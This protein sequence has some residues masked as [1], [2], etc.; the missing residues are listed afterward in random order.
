MKLQ[1]NMK[2]NKSK[3]IF[4]I[5]LDRT[6]LTLD[7]AQITGIGHLMFTFHLNPVQ[8]IIKGNQFLHMLLACS[9]I[10]LLNNTIPIK[11]MLI[12]NPQ[13]LQFSKRIAIM[14]LMKF[15]KVLKA[16]KIEK[17]HHLISLENSHHLNRN[18]K[19]NKR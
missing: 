3:K 9:K 4:H 17:Q 10:P 16:Y 12:N 8:K 5:Q 11:N 1:K 2:D 13:S 6:N 19:Y 7:Q 18:Y 14:V 15:S